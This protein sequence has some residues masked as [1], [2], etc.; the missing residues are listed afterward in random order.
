[1]V[2]VVSAA[3]IGGNLVG[4]YVGRRLRRPWILR[5]GGRFGVRAGHFERVER[6]FA[7]HG[8]KTV[9]LGRLS[10]PA[11]GPDALRGRRIA[12]PLPHLSPL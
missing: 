2:A 8:G 7:R 12:T 4:Y 6:F 5:H 9:L 1:M 11:A 10:P 3:S